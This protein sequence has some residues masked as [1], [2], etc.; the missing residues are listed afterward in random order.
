MSRL[1]R[2]ASAPQGDDC[3]ASTNRLLGTPP[4]SIGE[5][6]AALRWSRL[7]RRPADCGGRWRRKAATTALH[8]QPGQCFCAR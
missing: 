4:A 7:V 1:R 5:V 8:S 2:I 6:V 3:D